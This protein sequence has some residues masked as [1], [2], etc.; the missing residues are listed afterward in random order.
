MDD[1]ELP[2]TPAS[3]E[4]FNGLVDEKVLAPWGE[5]GPAPSDHWRQDVLGA[6][7]ESRTIPLMDDDAGPVVATLVRYRG[8]ASSTRTSSPAAP[9]LSPT[10]ATSPTDTHSARSE[11]P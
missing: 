1:I 9:A 7:Y 4:S 11:R 3:P 2:D 10:P 5:A 8:R 6:D